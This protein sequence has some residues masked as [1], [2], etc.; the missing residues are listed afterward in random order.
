MTAIVS[1][2]RFLLVVSVFCTMFAGSILLG[3]LSVAAE[4]SKKPAAVAHVARVTLASLLL[5]H[6]TKPNLGKKVLTTKPKDP[7]P[8]AIPH[9]LAASPFRP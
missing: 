1:K 8:P 9:R 4:T 7:V 6:D 2:R 5:A 3:G